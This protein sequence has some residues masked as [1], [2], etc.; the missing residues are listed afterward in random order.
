MHLTAISQFVTAT[1]GQGKINLELLKQLLAKGHSLEVI[2]SSIDDAFRS[3][4]GVHWIKVPYT[5]SLPTNWLRCEA[6]RL[7]AQRKV[8]GPVAINNGAAAIVPSK[9]NIAMFVHSAWL[10]SPSRKRWWCG[11]QP[12]IESSFTRQQ[13]M[14]EQRAFDLAETVVALSDQVR[15]ELIEFAGVS[16]SKIAVIPPGVD[17]KRFRPRDE[18]DANWLRETCGIK[19]QDDRFLLL[20]VGEIRSNRK[21]LDLVLENIL[22]DEELVLAVIGST[23]RSPYPEMAS[24]MG[25]SERVH[26]L[27]QRSDVAEL[28]P[29]A[30]CFVFPTNY[31]PFG[32]VIT[33]AMACGLPV[34]TTRH[35]G[36]ACVITDRI[37]GF[38]ITD[39]KDIDG[40][41]EVLS[42]LKDSL[43]R[44]GIASAARKKAE[45]LG[46]EQMAEKYSQILGC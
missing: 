37:D 12:L 30:D 10:K 27:G 7:Q 23:D 32:L 46:W 26:F 15:S 40:M 43:R 34:I 31:E 6:F 41:I 13:A 3:Q 39:G 20:F 42:N 8:H 45:T 35:A 24:R 14:L 25:I 5:T 18:C 9:L 44:N 4:A 19:K 36:A 17:T 33:E 16:E 38:L 2:C 28:M 11:L 29:G 22:R 1:H 21:N